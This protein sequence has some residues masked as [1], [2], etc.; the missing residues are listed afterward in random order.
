MVIESAERRGLGCIE[1]PSGAGHDASHLASLGPMAMI[2]VPSIAGIS[3]NAAETTP[4]EDLVAGAQVLLDVI[5]RADNTRADR[6]SKQ[7]R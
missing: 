3:H 4:P 6:T 2:F 1:L 5:R 7:A